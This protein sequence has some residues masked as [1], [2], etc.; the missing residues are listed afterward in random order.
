MSMTVQ[1]PVV[2]LTGDMLEDARIIA[3]AGVDEAVRAVTE[4]EGRFG[5]I[6][7]RVEVLDRWHWLFIRLGGPP[8][9]E[10]KAQL[11]ADEVALLRDKAAEEAD[12]TAY[13]LT[14]P[15]PDLV[16][17]YGEDGVARMRAHIVRA[18]R[19]RDYLDALT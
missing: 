10:S 11:N 8:A 13:W 18:E 19:V 3:I 1:D 12:A 14:D 16:E 4:D 7:R 2:T 9:R 17:G 5:E 6:L 15:L